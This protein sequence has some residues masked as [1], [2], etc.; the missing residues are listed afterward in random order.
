MNREPRVG[1][2]RQLFAA[3]DRII[4]GFRCTRELRPVFL[5]L[6]AALIA[7]ASAHA[8]PKG[9]QV[10]AGSATISQTN[11]APANSSQAAPAPTT[12]SQ[13]YIDQTSNRAVIDWQSFSIAPGEQTSF[14]QATPS[15]VTL[16]RVVSPN[17]PSVIAGKLTANGQI[18][19]IN[20]NGITFSKGAEVN[21]NSIL[22]TTTDI[23]N[24]N[25]M[26]GQMKFDIP[27]NNPG[28]TVV[29]RGEITVKQK[30][31]A[32]LVGPAAMNSGVIK[33]KLGKVVLGGAQTYTVDFYGDGLISFD[34]GP[35]VTTVPTGPDGRPVKSLV[36]N[37][38]R[39]DAPGG[40]VLLTADAAAGII[41]NVVNDSGRI[42]ART[43]GSTPGSVT[44][45]AGPAGAA[46]LSGKIDVSGLRPGQTGGSATVT[47]NSVALASTA[48]ID[49]RGDAG[50]GTVRVGG[51]AHGKDPTVHNATTTSVTAGAVIDASATAIG[52]GGKVTVWSDQAT[53]FAGTINALGGPNGGD[54]GWIEI[55][56]KGLLSFTGTVDTRAPNGVTGTL[57]LDPNDVE[58]SG[59][60]A[61]ANIT[62]TSPFQDDGTS[63]GTSVL[64]TKTLN[65]A[66]IS[67][68]VEVNTT[69]FSVVP[70]ISVAAT[71]PAAKTA[72]LGGTITVDADA[73][74]TWSSGNL[75]MLTADN[76][77]VVNGKIIATA[78]APATSPLGSILL[79]AGP[80]GILINGTIN[81]GF[82]VSPK[83]VV[84]LSA[85]GDIVETPSGTIVGDSLSVLTQKDA[86][87][88][89]SLNNPGNRV[90]GDVSLTAA[91]AA[92]TLLAP[93]D[94]SFSNSTGFVIA[95]V[96]GGGQGGLE[97][98]VGT[99]SN[100]LLTAAG[101]ITELDFPGVRV[102]AQNLVVD[103]VG[104]VAMG[105]ANSVDTLAASIRGAGNSF[106]F[107]ND[108][109]TLTIGTVGD[110]AGVTTNGGDIALHTTT[111]GDLTLSQNVNTNGGS[112]ALVSIGNVTES[113]G[114]ISA[115]A[116]IVNA[117]G[118]AVNLDGVNAVSTLAGA[119]AGTFQFVNGNAL[120][121][122]SV[123]AV[124]DVASQSGVLAL[125]ATRIR[126]NSG[127]LALA[128]EIVTGGCPTIVTTCDAPSL[129][130][131]AALVATTG[132]ATETTGTVTASELIVTAGGGVTFNNQNSVTALSGTAG[133]SF[134][135]VNGHALS[136]DSL[137]ILD[138][139][140]SSG[141]V[142]GLVTA[143]NVKLATISGN[144]NV[145]ED[146]TATG[147]GVLIGVGGGG[148][149]N[150]SATIQSTGSGFDGNIVILADAMNLATAGFDVPGSN[151]RA[152]S[153]SAVVLAPFT[154]ANSI[155]LGAG[156][157]AGTLGLT[158]PELGTVVA[159]LLQIGDF[160]ES[161]DIRIS[162]AIT[163][164]PGQ[165]PNLAL[166]TGGGV[167]QAPGA[168]LNYPGG[169]LG[170]IAGNSVTLDG[171]NVVDTVAGVVNN[172][173]QN[174]LFNNS[175]TNLTIGDLLVQQVGVSVD[176]ATNF[177]IAS[178]TGT[179][180]A[181]NP[182]TGIKT[183]GGNIVLETLTSG[184]LALNQ[185]VDAGNGIV[186]LASAGTITQDPAPIIASSL[187]I[188]SAER[189]SLGAF[190]GA[191]DLNQV[192]TLAAQ[193]LNPGES[194]VFRNDAENLMI[195]TVV[196]PPPL[197][198]SVGSVSTATLS[199][200]VTNNANL[201]LRVTGA[202]SGVGLTLNAPVRAG[203]GNVGLES[204]GGVLQS[205][206][207]A[208]TAA[209]LEV[210]SLQPVSLGGPNAVQLLAGQV[211]GTP[212]SPGSSS[213]SLLLR[214][215]S[216]SLTVGSV[217]PLLEQG[218][219]SSNT[220]MLSVGALSG[221]VTN[222][223]V[224]ELQTTNAGNLTLNGNLLTTGQTS[225]FTP[226][227]VIL[228][229]AGMITQTSGIISA[230]T[231]FGSSVG[232]VSLPGN[233]LVGTFG[234]FANAAGGLLS[235][236]DAQS[237]TTA[238]AVSSPGGLALSTTGAGSN[239]TLG[240][241]L[242]APGQT[243]TL[244]SAGT[245]TEQPGGTIAAAML[246]G[247]SAGSAVFGQAGNQVAN[248]GAFATGNGDFT[249][250]DGQALN[251]TGL[252]NAGTGVVTLNA[253]GTITEL[254]G[255]SITAA[256]LTGSSA[257]NA[258]FGQSGNLVA[259]LGGFATT[260]G[261]NN[262]NFT[263][264]NGAALNLTGLV[265]AGTG[266][267]TLT[268]AGPIAEQSSGAIRAGML[269]GS[270]VGGTTLNQ[271]N[272][273]TDFGPFTNTGPGG[274]TLTNGQPLNVTG[275]LGAGAG[276]LALT[277]TGAGSNLTLGGN[278][279]APGQT[280]T[281]SSAGTITQD[282][283]ITA[284]NLVART[285]SDAGVALTLAN[286]A[287]DVPGNVTLS[288]LNS[289]GTAPAAGDINF[290]DSSG[291]T[292][293]AQ[294]GN[295]L[296][297]QEIGIN[298]TSSIDL[299]SSGSL[300]VAMGGVVNGGAVANSLFTLTGGNAIIVNGQIGSSASQVLFDSGLGGILIGGPINAPKTGFG[301]GAPYAVHMSSTGA[302]TETSAGTIATQS[303]YA[304]TENDL[305]APILLNNVG[306]AITEVG[307]SGIL[308]GRVTLTALNGATS[309]PR[310][311]AKGDISLSSS[312]GFGIEPFNG[313]GIGGLELGI[314]TAA[315]AVLNAG[316]PI[317]DLFPGTRIAAA[318]LT[319]S[320]MGG[321]TLTT[322]N[323]VTSLGSFINIGAGGFALTNGQTLN[324]TGPVNAGTGGLAL[325]TTSGNLVVGAALT[326]G[327]TVMLNSSGTLTEQSGGLISAA[328]LS[329]S[330]VGGATL[331]QTN[332]VTDFGPFTNT[333]PGGLT[334]TNGQPL[335]VTGALG[336]GA[337]GLALTTTGAGSNLTLGGNLAAPGQTVTL[338][339][340]GTITEQPG[341][342]ITAAMLTGSSV[343]GANLSQGNL[344]STFGPF[345]NTASGLLSF[346]DAQALETAGAVSSAGG[347]ALKT[348]GTGSNLT[349][350]GNLT[351]SGQPVTL[352][353]AGTITEVNDP[354]VAASNLTVD[355]TGKVSLGIDG[356]TV[357]PANANTVGTLTGTAGGTFGFL[358]ATDLTVGAVA[359]S[360]GDVLIQ[361]NNAGQSL[362]LAGNIT[363]TAG[364]RVILDTA[365][366][367]SQIG[368]VTV[369]AP[370][371]AIDTT[372][373]GVNTLLGFITSPSSPNA[374]FNLP[375]AGKMSH[376]IQF[377]NLM[378]PNTVML[379]FADQG[380][381]A[382]PIQAGQLGLSGTGSLANLQG[383]IN[384]VAGPTAALLGVRDPGPSPG[385]LLNDCIIAATTC[386]V[387]PAAQPLAFLVSQPQTASEI[388]ALSVSPNLSAQF[389]LIEPEIVKGVR[390]SGDP[391]APVIN[392][393][394]EERLCDETAKSSQPTREPCREER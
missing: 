91:N 353:S 78:T 168:A 84:A 280:V 326:A 177:P 159:G 27:S 47:G 15:S 42:I 251:L 128:S 234:P 209:G 138:V 181:T 17:D 77:I 284:Q 377:G 11:P 145:F 262:G 265:N 38:G 81:G 100:A 203:F 205:P 116:L 94:I 189:V 366:G 246:T 369:N 213:N 215:D 298:T 57:L 86:G 53:Q 71:T 29:N 132:N 328:T 122:G 65:N 266:V 348:T 133:T 335:N 129:P 79:G 391:D 260:A 126:A 226:E 307:S 120:T 54:G 4:S 378:A 115:S 125:G 152:G 219:G 112:V 363:A 230:S 257:G 74:V 311:L 146:V 131:P 20:Q 80:G 12:G 334:L 45:D 285:E 320:S 229:S 157:S 367:F 277:T 207:T 108:S 135:F 333:G 263:L 140:T 70:T 380:S 196:L 6:A 164:N 102:A 106:L 118:T 347:I 206:S 193:V 281:L 190:G 259:N 208:I 373:A 149:F 39:I 330:S 34:V 227:S 173:S 150:N 223:G 172:A 48:R 142:A 365:G 18:V 282:A 297:G 275:A 324:V 294:P 283:P 356:G 381:V 199:G 202:V 13:L 60:K 313:S 299:T 158:G 144:L 160:A 258:L 336:A 21:V 93:G 314:N 341:G 107:R 55:S 183:A 76:A 357:V 288:A 374:I 73:T 261:G 329:G 315:N 245:I 64:S 195:G 368:T 30:G 147:G 271:T 24:A 308:P 296:N 151:I 286:P 217:G 310:V 220:Q 270:S 97:L 318:T 321:T 148:S 63:A 186:G 338:N 99:A 250:T 346:T 36:S 167:S 87:A 75:L 221:V 254:A 9:G 267:V 82:P 225:S 389:V 163:V 40:T 119:S 154:P 14:H 327:T 268:V 110:A 204:A 8:N 31:L 371:L 2:V 43:S 218:T 376:P 19:L 256:T 33:A 85:T 290:V 293:A 123:P 50:G 35:K 292:I 212:P 178:T 272:L 92:G 360:A 201:G 143:G 66:L 169:R 162:S 385:Y 124:L 276:G 210:S 323:R 68:N 72:P 37:T 364:G 253:T 240:G 25:F 354:T 22:A 170:A 222:S 90:T 375:P 46:N 304:L 180:S 41:G 359:A 182:V 214:N 191:S 156:N 109:K 111:R 121:V 200:V 317:T 244:N 243:V 62:T 319:G 273:V 28:A 302:I 236:T 235:F 51:G 211:M 370:V 312:T 291:F 264:T 67:T 88:R 337:G 340:A 32:A 339:S 392:I 362:T 89:I 171:S 166:V 176:A 23:S 175:R 44:I 165:T 179:G 117:S 192:G 390:Q 61:D 372:G 386:V 305:G 58:I 56:S 278:L 95:S 232:G 130:Q 352:T 16:N 247:S 198:L 255:G 303:L 103:A 344:V 188:L 241:N 101:P 26:K 289:A 388:Q 301:A 113:G 384:G 322:L 7:A 279:T 306:N 134:Q 248:L 10:T 139:T 136:I 382:G 393:F 233:N 98:G 361:V 105:N 153:G 269:T 3:G 83:Y 184:N 238:G 96:G 187:A 114:I 224:I 383:S 239:L 331:N 379:L 342:I 295:G 104:P 332:L 316:G 231:L 349:L 197:T 59:T 237:L 351:A 141:I 358:N 127:D 345:N 343:G 216:T 325:T 249:L 5:A 49:A 242:T 274:L 350:G 287:N 52:N 252:L 387:I 155:A 161:G 1:G 309:G 185:T 300:T 137:G 69:S 355:A 394:D 174:F 194:F 228:T